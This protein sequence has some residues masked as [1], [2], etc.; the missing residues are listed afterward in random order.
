VRAVSRRLSSLDAVDASQLR[1]LLVRRG[2]IVERSPELN[3]EWFDRP[4]LRLDD[5]GIIEARRAQA[6]G[7]YWQPPWWK[8]NDSTQ[9]RYDRDR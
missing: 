6:R 1:A 9:R 4:T 2:V 8:K 7:L 3:S 5:A